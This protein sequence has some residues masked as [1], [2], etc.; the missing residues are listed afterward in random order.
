MPAA[1]FV[2]EGFVE[3]RHRAGSQDLYAE[4]LALM[5]RS[6]LTRVLRRTRGNQTQAAKV[7]GITRGIL[8][9]RIRTLGIEIERPVWSTGDQPGR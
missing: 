6:L 7:M 8:G 9:T 3:D 5:E 2:W 1:P 4:A